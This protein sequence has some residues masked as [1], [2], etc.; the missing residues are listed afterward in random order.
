MQASQTGQ[1]SQNSMQKS[2]LLIFRGFCIE[3]LIDIR[4]SIEFTRRFEYFGPDFVFAIAEVW[5]SMNGEK[6][7]I[8]PGDHPG[9]FLEDLNLMAARVSALPVVSCVDSQFQ[10][11]DWSSWMADYWVRVENDA[12]TEA[13]ETLYEKLIALSFID[14]RTGSLAIYKC[15]NHS[16][17][18]VG[19]RNID[20]EKAF[21]VWSEFDSDLLRGDI[22]K[23]GESILFDIKSVI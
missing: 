11:G 23:I 10:C 12:A 20:R 21:S 5:L 19:V 8:S 14:T 18:E 17:V 7:I 4:R 3:F 1:E 6:F 15:A 13:D 9:N 2:Y 22:L 16:V